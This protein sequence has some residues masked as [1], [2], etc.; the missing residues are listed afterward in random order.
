MDLRFPILVLVVLLPINVTFPAVVAG[1]IGGSAALVVVSFPAGHGG[2]G[3]GWQRRSPLL[4]FAGL[5]LYLARR[6]L[7]FFAAWEAMVAS[8]LALKVGAAA[9][10]LGV[11]IRRLADGWIRRLLG[12]KGCRAALPSACAPRWCAHAARPRRSGSSARAQLDLVEF[13]ARDWIAFC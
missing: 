1:E 10:L 11:L 5:A 8:D 4:R 9:S 12:L 13:L 3:E 6:L 2:V 7:P